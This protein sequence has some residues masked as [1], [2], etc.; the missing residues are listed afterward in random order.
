MPSSVDDVDGPYEHV[1]HLL[2]DVVWDPDDGPLHVYSEPKPPEYEL[3]E[4][5]GVLTPFP[6][7]TAPEPDPENVM[8]TLKHNLHKFF[9]ISHP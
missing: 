8:E 2:V 1:H 5:S 3:A 7:G 4:I 6:L 9:N